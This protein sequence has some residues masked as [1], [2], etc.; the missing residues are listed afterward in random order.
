VGA[1]A[2]RVATDRCRVGATDNGSVARRVL[3]DHRVAGDC[4][5]QRAPDR[6][7]NLGEAPTETERGSS[8]SCRSGYFRAIME[9]VAYC[10][11]CEMDRDSCEHGL[12]ER[13]RTAS[14]SASILLIS[15]ASLVHFPRCPHKGGD[16]DYS[17][18]AELDTPRGWECP[19]NGE[20][21]P[22][23]GGSR[24][25]LVAMTRCQDCLDHGPW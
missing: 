21:L 24:R 19:G 23:T 3:P 17:R 12:A 16:P 2:L 5:S 1:L 20:Q 15:P 7:L 22:A 8:P 14:A 13:R 9:G 18:W 10:S 4:R 25:D 11:L 6:V